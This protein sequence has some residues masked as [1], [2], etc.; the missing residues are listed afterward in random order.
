MSAKA[1]EKPDLARVYAVL[2]FQLRVAE[3]LDAQTQAFDELTGAECVTAHNILRAMDQ[4][5]LARWQA[6]GMPNPDDVAL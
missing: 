4:I 6:E 2:H 1:D 3:R 5:L